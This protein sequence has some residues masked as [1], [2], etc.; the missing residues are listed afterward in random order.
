MPNHLHGILFITGVGAKHLMHDSAFDS[1]GRFT[2]ASPLRT[3]LG[4]KT[5]SLSAVMQNFK[6]VTTRKINRIRRTPSGQLW[7]RNYYEHIVR[8]ENDLNQVREYIV[9]NPLKW[10]LDKENPQNWRG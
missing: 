1:N 10:E 9:N 4:T 6:S 7:Q 8:N 2:N 3:S 5:G